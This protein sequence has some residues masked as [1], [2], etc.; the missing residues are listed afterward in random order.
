MSDW[1]INPRHHMRRAT[2]LLADG[3]DVAVYLQGN[4]HASLRAVRAEELFVDEADGV[5]LG[6]GIK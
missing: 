1:R 4:L 2:E 5:R 6:E 3:E